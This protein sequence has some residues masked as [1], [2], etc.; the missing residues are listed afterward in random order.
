MSEDNLTVNDHDIG[1]GFDPRVCLG[2]HPDVD[3]A[4]PKLNSD[5]SGL[6]RLAQLLGSA[7]GQDTCGSC[8]CTTAL[9]ATM[10]APPTRDICP[11]YDLHT[12]SGDYLE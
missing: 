9:M 8:G 1:A 11:R 7:A 6:G 4:C 5:A 2:T 3:S 10:E 12:N